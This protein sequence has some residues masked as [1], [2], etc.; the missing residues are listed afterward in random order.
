MKTAADEL[1]I[2]GT[3]G[4]DVFVGKK[5]LRNRY[6]IDEGDVRWVDSIAHDGGPNIIITQVMADAIFPDEDPL[7]KLVV[8]GSGT[9]LTVIG[10]LKRAQAVYWAP[11]DEYASFTPGRVNFN[12][13]YLVRI[14]R[15]DLGAMDFAEAKTEVMTS[16]SEKLQAEDP[17]REVLVE[18]IDEVKK[19]NLGRYIIINSIIG[20]VAILL[21]V[22]TAFGNY[23]QMSY[24]ILKRTKQIGI[25]RALGATRGYI[26]KYFLAEHAIVT[27]L[28]MI[29]G[30]L[31][32]LG[33]NFV[34]IS[35]IGYGNFEWQHIAICM[36]F[37]LI[38]GFLSA[39]LPVIRATT[40]SPAVAT[41][42]V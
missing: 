29:P 41:Q 26:F 20:S 24:T 16:L 38:V 33:L 8:N 42:T 10:I 21:I 2:K 27:I 11:Y 32:M 6:L 7:G 28:G 37:M 23:G 5:S 30:G 14:D 15:S 36:T 22:V 13:G 4:Q 19:I 25:R 18:T 40:I 17:D 35:A 1:Q 3:A 9:T 12:E 31:L 39:L 34:I